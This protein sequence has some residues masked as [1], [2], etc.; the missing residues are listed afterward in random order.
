MWLGRVRRYAYRDP[1]NALSEDVS[2]EAP[3]LVQ[4]RERLERS[5]ESEPKDC[6]GRAYSKGWESPS[7]RVSR[8]ATEFRERCAARA[9]VEALGGRD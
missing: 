3:M 6:P 8:R 7:R 4:G 9:P 1:K 2:I 5:P